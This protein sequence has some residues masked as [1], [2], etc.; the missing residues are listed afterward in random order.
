MKESKVLIII[1]AQ[2]DFIDG[3][4]GTPEAVEAAEKICEIIANGNYRNVYFT[5]DLHEDDTYLSTNEGKHLPIKHCLRGTEGSRINEKIMKTVF[6]K[7]G[8]EEKT[9][10]KD[11]F[12]TLDW[13]Y[14]N[15]DKVSSID[16]VGFC[17]DICVITNALILKTLFPETEIN[18]IA[19]GCAGTTPEAHK[20]SLMVMKSCQI[21]VK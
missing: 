11:T 5:K 10:H 17:T 9:L 1:D 13:Q 15:L 6:T 4:L 14:T 16:I 2:N 19:E 7:I 3:V 12:G 21:E 8:V 18:V 20:A